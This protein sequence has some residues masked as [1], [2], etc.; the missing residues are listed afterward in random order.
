[1][2]IDLNDLVNLF[3]RERPARVQCDSGM[4]FELPRSPIVCNDGFEISVQASAGHYCTPKLDG[5][6]W[7][8]SVEVGFPSENVEALEQYRQGTVDV[9]TWVPTAEVN[10]ILKAH[11]GIDYTRTK[12]N[13]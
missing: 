11:N 13:L 9:F 10:E 3:F 5:A 2:D 7:Y 12:E 6:N 1:M 8:S 4:D